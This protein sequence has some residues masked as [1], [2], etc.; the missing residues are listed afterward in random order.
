MKSN[1]SG[2]RYKCLICYD[3]DLCG[4]CYD[5]S[6]AL[7]SITNTSSSSSSSSIQNET[8][9]SSKS[10][11]KLKSYKLRVS[12]PAIQVVKPPTAVSTTSNNIK[13]NQSSHLNTHAMQCILTRGDQEL[14]YGS[15]GGRGITCDFTIG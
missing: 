10:N 4:T 13:I 6:Q 12:E 11:K 15:G 8:I 3:F 2:K 5:Q 14:F 9:S 7:I 1:F